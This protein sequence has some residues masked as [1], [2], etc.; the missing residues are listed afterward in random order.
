VEDVQIG[1][2][3]NDWNSMSKAYID[4]ENNFREKYRE[5]IE[6]RIQWLE[7]SDDRLDTM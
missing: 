7:Q 5:A 2:S 4:V 6:K 1:F 3:K